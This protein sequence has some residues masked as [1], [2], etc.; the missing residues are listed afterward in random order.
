MQKKPIPGLRRVVTVINV[1]ASVLVVLVAVLDI[2]DL[3]DGAMGLFIFL[4][5]VVNLCRAYLVWNTDRDGAALY[6]LSTIIVF[7]VTGVIFLMA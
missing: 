6:L 4:L 3:W 5:G 2:L 7:A 1:A